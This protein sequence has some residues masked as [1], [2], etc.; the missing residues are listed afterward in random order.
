LKM[1]VYNDNDNDKNVFDIMAIGPKSTYVTINISN[2]HV[3][4]Y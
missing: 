1:L 4:V 3:T 2:E